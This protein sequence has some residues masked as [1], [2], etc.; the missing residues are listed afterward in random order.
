MTRW[1]PPSTEASAAAATL[2][3][4]VDIPLPLATVLA[5]RG[6][7]DPAQVLSFLRPGLDQQHDPL[8]LPDM[9]AAIRRINRAI[10]DGETILVHGDFDPDGMCATAVATLGL[11]RLGAHVVPFVPHRIRDGYDFGAAGIERARSCRASLVITVD[12]GMRA[13][14]AV[15]EAAE[16]GI[17][18]L[19][20]DHHQPGPQLPA[21]IAIVNP[22]RHDNGYPFDQLAGVGV[23]FKIV[24]ALFADHGIPVEELN[25]HL[26]LVAVGTVADRMP[27]LGENRAMVRAGLRVLRQTYKPGLR[28]LLDRA[29]IDRQHGVMADD[30]AFR[31]GPLLNAAGRMAEA[32]TG[33]RLLLAKTELEAA[34]LADQLCRHNADRKTTNRRLTEEVH[35][36]ISRSFVAEKDG[37]LVVWGD[38]WHQGVIGIVASQVVDCWNRP[39]VVVAFDGNTGRGSGRSVEGFDLHEALE[40]CKSLLVK[41][42]GHS[43]AAGLTIE[44]ANIEEFARKLNE[45]A[46][47][48][49]TDGPPE[50]TRIIDLE[51]DLET[52]D[53]DLFQS[54]QHLMP[55][56][57]GNPT[58]ILITNRVQFSNMSVVGDGGVHLRASLVRNGASL[59]AIGFGLGERLREVRK[60]VDYDVAFHLQ[61]DTWK[62]R[63]RLQAQV[64]D[65]RS[66]DVSP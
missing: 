9:P 60:D 53:F 17:D 50:K 24:A 33:L 35:E 51:V 11:Q 41:F 46:S 36:I 49:L 20:S 52:I 2:L 34:P 15:D 65:F 44:R 12:C 38:D 6:I 37:A 64:I 48:R 66:V 18:V 1:I 7:R 43:K 23:A 19:V 8:L 22:K 31:V 26:D 16:L 39:A 61:S 56:G 27:L 32:E 47:D 29:S 21:A 55:F 63:R 40:S 3:S 5:V 14:E 30:I 58:P 57:E 59:Q 45:L 42:G 54:L 13:V 28:E 10:D 25:Q 4:G 62:G